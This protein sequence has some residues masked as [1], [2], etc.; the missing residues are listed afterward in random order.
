MQKILVVEDNLDIQ[1]LFKSFLYEAGDGVVLANDSVKILFIFYVQLDLILLDL[2][3]SKI[4]GL[5]SAS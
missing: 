4:G 2:M 3:L 1:E 5:G